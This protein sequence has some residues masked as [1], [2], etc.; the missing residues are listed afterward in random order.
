MAS[1]Y[2]RGDYNRGYGPGGGG[3]GG[4][5]GRS[6]GGP[7][8]GRGGGG[9]GERRGIPLSELPTELTE[10][11]R[12]LIG[13]AIEVHKALGP[14]YDKSVYLAAVRAE[15]DAQQI[16]YKA[17]H[18]VP[19]KYRDKQIGTVK[20]DLFVEDRFLVE[21]MSRHGE[22]STSERLALR[23]QLKAANLDLGLIINFS[24]RRL[25]DGLVRVLNVDKINAERGVS[26]D[27]PDHDGGQEG[28]SVHDFDTH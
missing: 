16:V 7:R 10:S 23:A 17:D 24:E 3:G 8:G 9:G 26:F 14:G 20:S 25:K 12:K 5:G 1:E 18:V 28:S 4:G 22:V 2:P 13:V 27:D 11:S 21:V 15:L 19:V 6:G